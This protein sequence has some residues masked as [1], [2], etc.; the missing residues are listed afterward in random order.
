MQHDE[1]AQTQT[2]TAW[3]QKLSQEPYERNN[4][5][6]ATA[7]AVQDLLETAVEQNPH[8]QPENPELVQQLEDATQMAL[9]LATDAATQ[10]AYTGASIAHRHR[11]PQ[12]AKEAVEK[13]HIPAMAQALSIG[14]T[15]YA[16]LITGWHDRDS[17][18]PD[19]L[20]LRRASARHAQQV[21]D[22]IGKVEDHLLRL[23]GPSN[24]YPGGVPISPERLTTPISA[25]PTGPGHTAFQ[26]SFSTPGRAPISVR[27]SVDENGRLTLDDHCQVASALYQHPE[28]R[29]ERG[30]VLAQEVAEHNG[31]RLDYAKARIMKETTPDTLVEDARTLLS[32]IITIT[33]AEPAMNALVTEPR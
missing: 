26:T 28:E 30:L 2:L 7:D 4:A 19:S 16:K 14:A 22:H 17:Q 12:S 21:L 27:L 31:A 5:I 25:V 13:V 20:N 11:E 33:N 18:D 6:K 15:V 1:A 32:V 8:P 29:Y 23:Y 24:R 10:A 3:L 9:N